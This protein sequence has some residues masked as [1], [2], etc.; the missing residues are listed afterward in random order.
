MK[1]DGAGTLSFGSAPGSTNRI[2]VSSNSY[3]YSSTGNHD[4]ILV[5]VTS[6]EAVTITLPIA[7]AINNIVDIV[8]AAGNAGTNNITIV[9][10]ANETIVG[11]T[12]LVINADYNSVTL[13]PNGS[14]SWLII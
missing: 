3:T 10:N 7:S 1:T 9:P 2:N 13:Y 8:D 11:E 4:I 6:S 5:S 14:T 12:T